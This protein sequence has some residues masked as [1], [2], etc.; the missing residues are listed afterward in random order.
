LIPVALHE[1]GDDDSH[2]LV[3]VLALKGQYLRS[4]AVGH[5]G[6]LLDGSGLFAECHSTMR[7]D[8]IMT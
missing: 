5:A 3:G 8:A 6:V 2:S 4:G 7:M 1:R